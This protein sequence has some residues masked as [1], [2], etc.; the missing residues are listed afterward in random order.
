MGKRI[1]KCNTAVVVLCAIATIIIFLGAMNLS[2]YALQKM[3]IQ[4]PGFGN[5]MI[6]EAVGGICDLLL[7]VLF[8]YIRIL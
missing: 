7:L 6:T 3:Q 1:A 2:G 4:C 8:G 5:M